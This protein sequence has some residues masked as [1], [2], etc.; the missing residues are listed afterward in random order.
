M[1]TLGKTP[2]MGVATALTLAF[3]H[4][5]RTGAS[6]HR[7]KL[8]IWRRTKRGSA[9]PGQGSLCRLYPG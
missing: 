6:G 1:T 9:D 2:R 7:G 3:P 8:F 4:D 5:R